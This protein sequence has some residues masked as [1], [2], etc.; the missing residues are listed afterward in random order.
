MSPNIDFSKID[1]AATI[2]RLYAILCI[3]VAGFCL[4]NVTAYSAAAAVLVG[5]HIF[6][7][8]RYR[9]QLEMPSPSMKQ[10]SKTYLLFFVTFV[11]SLVLLSH[12]HR[13]LPQTILTIGYALLHLLDRYFYHSFFGSIFSYYAT[14]NNRNITSKH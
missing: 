9:D 5:I 7:G 10:W 3:G 8:K 12:E 14:D 2:Y 13:D 11:C 1:I 4:L 6:L